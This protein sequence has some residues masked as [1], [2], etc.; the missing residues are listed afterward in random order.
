VLRQA[1]RKPKY[2]LNPVVDDYNMS[3]EI[4]YEKNMKP[5]GVYS[6]LEAEWI[7][8]FAWLPKR[9]DITNERIWL[10]DYYEYVITMD[11]QGAVPKKGKDWRMIYTREEYITKK[12]QGEI[13]E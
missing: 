8:Q 5:I 4:L 13:N 11:S 6:N 9:S 12:L 1:E 10:T 2:L 7:K 3:N